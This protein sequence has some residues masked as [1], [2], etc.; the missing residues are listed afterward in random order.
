VTAKHITL[1]IPSRPEA[2]ATVR[3]ALRGLGNDENIPTRALSR[4]ELCVSEAVNNCIKHAYEN[5][6]DR[7]VRVEWTSHAHALELAICDTGKSM[8]PAL[9]EQ[10]RC[11][12]PEIDPDKPESLRTSGWGLYLISGFMD[13]VE[14]QAQSSGNRLVMRLARDRLREDPR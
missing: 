10:A 13:A 7:E 1:S 3:A 4:I 8:D 6:P 12:T 5:S 11:A 2:V 9:L 14:Y